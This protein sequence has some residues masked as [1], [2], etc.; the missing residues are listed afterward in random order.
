M[1]HR[2]KRFQ[3]LPYFKELLPISGATGSNA[4]TPSSSLPPPSSSASPLSS[5]SV[6]LP[7]SS[8]VP[9]VSSGFA[10]PAQPH[11][12]DHDCAMTASST[13]RVATIGNDSDEM[14]VDT[15]VGSASSVSKHKHSDLILPGDDDENNDDS[16][17]LGHLNI[18]SPSSNSVSRNLLSPTVPTVPSVPSAPSAPSAPSTSF[19]KSSSLPKKKKTA[20]THNSAGQNSSSGVGAPS[21]NIAMKIT[22]AV[23]IHGM[24]GTLN[25]LTDVMERNLGPSSSP[26]PTSSLRT[27]A[28][29]LLQR[30]KDNLEVYEKTKV[31]RMFTDNIGL[32]EVYVALEDDELCRD[33][34]QDLLLK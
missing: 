30:R 32:A 11:G 27:Q 2:N 25:R 23:A 7:S 19:H 29:I 6:P 13:M 12:S 24:Q 20:L 33:W 34:L 9:Q 28:I 26:D 3:W 14:D 4:F 5:L 18:T 17:V 15:A 31:I 21:G 10:V 16:S 22:P 8:S 1:L